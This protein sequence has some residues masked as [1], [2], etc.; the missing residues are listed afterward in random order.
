MK[1]CII[2]SLMELFRKYIQHEFAERSRKNPSYSLRAFAQKLGINHATLST[3]LNGKRK[4]TRETA[5]RLGQQLGLS[6]S[7]LDSLLIE[8]KQTSSLRYSVLQNDAFNRMADWYFDA[9]LELTLIPDFPMSPKSI[10]S[11][12]GISPLQAT[13]ALETLE[14]LEL[15][16]LSANGAYELTNQNTTNILDPDYTSAANRK[17]QKAILSKSQE[18]LD[19]CDRKER[20]HTST[21]LAIDIRDLPRAKKIIAEF[22]ANLSALL[23]SPEKAPNEVYQLQVS[24]FP[25]SKINSSPRRIP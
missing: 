20:D 13:I 15:L 17:Y 19:L 18:A 1:Q 14:S 5:L 22:R 23:Q 2:T 21:T 6:P 3:I 7:E 11:A 4:L 9:I 24:F 10:S 16:K 12:L 25:L 8:E